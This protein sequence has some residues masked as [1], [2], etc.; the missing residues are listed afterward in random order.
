MSFYAGGA[1]AIHVVL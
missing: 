1:L